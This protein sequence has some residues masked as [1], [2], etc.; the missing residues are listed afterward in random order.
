MLLAKLYSCTTVILFC[1]KVPVLSEHITLTEPKVSTAGSLLTIALFLDILVTP[2]ERTIAT[3]ATRPSG[4][5]A[6]ANETAVINI[7][8]ADLPCKTPS[9]NITKHTI[10]AI[11]PNV[12]PKVSNFL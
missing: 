7:S 3:I 10:I 8:R 1:V 2:V 11:Y 5:A 9:I 4:I 6:T 12:L